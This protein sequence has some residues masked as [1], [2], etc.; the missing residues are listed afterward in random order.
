MDQAVLQT[1]R[2]DFPKMRM[3]SS[4]DK[5]YKDECVMSFETPYSEGGLYVNLNSWQGYGR[6]HVGRDV[7]RSGSKVYLHQR[8]KQVLKEEPAATE[9]E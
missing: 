8:W 9:A 1:I 2:G 5:V 7:E 3:P 4:F 6:A